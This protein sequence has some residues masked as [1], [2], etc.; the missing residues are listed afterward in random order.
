MPVYTFNPFD[1][2]SGFTGTTEAFGVND[3]D[4]IVGS[5]QNATGIHGF[6]ESGGTFITL[7]D[8]LATDS[9]V[10][11]GINGAGQI[12]GDYQDVNF[13][14]HGFLLSGGVYTALDDPSAAGTTVATGINA[15]DQIVGFYFDAATGYHGFLF[16]PTGGKFPPT[17]PSTI[18]Q[19]ARP[20]PPVSMTQVRLSG[21]MTMP[22]VA[23]ASSLAAAFTPPW[24]TLWP[25]RAP[26][27]KASIILAR[28]SATISAPP[29]ATPSSTA[30]DFSLLSTI[31]LKYPRSPCIWHQQQ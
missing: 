23:T 26:L 1:D 16:D 27:P 30:G 25:P 15:K 19:P 6:L 17:S 9:T 10:A 21:S 29:A 2:P 28:S 31:P 12:V 7:D 18:P 13:D 3:A 20:L 8:P 11:R 14:N 24:T 4:Q 5:Y 22:P